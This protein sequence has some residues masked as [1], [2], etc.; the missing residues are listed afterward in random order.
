MWPINPEFRWEPQRSHRATCRVE[1]WSAGKL[2]EDDAEILDGSVTEKRVTGLRASLSL[3]VPPSEEWLGWFE[4]PLLEIRTFAGI[5]WKRSFFQCPLGVFPLMPP[6][7]K[8]PLSEISF[9]ADDRWQIVAQ[10]D[11]LYAWQGPAGKASQLAA[12]LMREAGFDSVAID[13]TQDVESPALMWD[14][15]R[16]DLISG[17]LE[18]INAEAFVDRTGQAVIRDRATAVGRDL[19]DGD[20]GTVVSISSTQDWSG[21]YNAIGVTSSKT[22]VVLP[23]VIVSIKDPL[24]PAH[25]SRIG[26]RSLQYSS[27]LISNYGDAYNAGVAKLEKVSAPALSWTV[28]CVPDPTRMPGD[29]ITVTTELGVVKAV[30]QEVTHPLGSGSQKIRLA[31]P[32]S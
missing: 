22:D 6:E 27:Q 8:L 12:R 9:S 21:V 32:L 3:S 1:V 31:A 30:V 20:D 29:L 4:L 24:H 28:S 25:Y 14:K 15:S 26:R 5:S 19:T 13:V 16:H 11:L 2:I 17:Y 7:R 23:P 10:N 18:P